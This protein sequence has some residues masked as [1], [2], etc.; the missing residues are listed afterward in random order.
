MWQDGGSSGSIYDDPDDFDAEETG[1]RNEKLEKGTVSDGGV[2]VVNT[3]TVTINLNVG[4]GAMDS[5]NIRRG[6]DDEE[7]MEKI[8][9]IINTRSEDLKAEVQ[10][11]AEN[12]TGRMFEQ[13]EKKM[14]LGQKI[15]DTLISIV[16]E[17]G[18]DKGDTESV[19]VKLVIVIVLGCVIV[20]IIIVAVYLRYRLVETLVIVGNGKEDMVKR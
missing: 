16:E 20:C 9:Q 6:R 10:N 5:S 15:N 1:I 13:E 19:D 2:K 8:K 3:N 7:L 17:A 4:Q 14:E 18:G 12:R 11:V